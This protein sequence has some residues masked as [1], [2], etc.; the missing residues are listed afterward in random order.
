MPNDVAQSE[1][2]QRVNQHGFTLL[3]IML[4][5]VLL[6]LA[7]SAIL[8][9]IMPDDSGALMQKEARRMI[10]L[11]QT[12]QEKALLHGMDMGLQQTTEGYRFLVYK[13]GK[14]QPVS[15]D[16]MLSPVAL[17]ESLRFTILPGESVWRDTLDL[18]QDNGFTFDASD[19]EASSDSEHEAEP[20]LFFWT[21][22]EISPAELRLFSAD[23]PRHALSINLKEH[24]E[25]ALA[26]GVKR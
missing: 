5:M 26:E 19:E 8:P 22:G 10:M 13:Q 1:A 15:G 21:S 20:D 16:R 2:G 25:I 7:I 14:W 9:S 12:S 3:E 23:A 17:N 18:E 4:V 11:A 24:G 6:G